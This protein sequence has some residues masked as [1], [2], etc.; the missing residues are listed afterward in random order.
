[1]IDGIN[2]WLDLITLHYSLVCE[3]QTLLIYIAQIRTL[4]RNAHYLAGSIA[5]I[6]TCL[7]PFIYAS[8]YEPFRR[9]LKKMLNKTSVITPGKHC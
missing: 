1:M 3:F 6:T 2:M 9:E 8:R 4:D 7:D 5:Y